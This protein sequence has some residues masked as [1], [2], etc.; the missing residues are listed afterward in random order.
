MTSPTLEA[1]DRVIEFWKTVPDEKVDMHRV[2]AIGD[3]GCLLY[4]CGEFNNKF[5][6]KK[7]P[8]KVEEAIKIT[9]SAAYEIEFEDKLFAF[10]CEGYGEKHKGTAG[11]QECLKRLLELREKV[12]GGRS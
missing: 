8:R 6:N 11:K 9:S 2:G 4:H 7:V 1:I 12:E 10:D 3:C 5:N